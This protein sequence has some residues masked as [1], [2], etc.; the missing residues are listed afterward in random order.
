MVRARLRNPRKVFFDPTGQP[1]NLFC[2]FAAH[3]GETV[4]HSPWNHEIG[5]AKN[6]SVG[7]QG[8]QGLGKHFFTHALQLP[9][10]FT[11]A[12]RAFQK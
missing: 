7:L 8:L 3:D 12:M 6:E 2:N 9:S 1:L 4:V 11:K 5:F 10:Q